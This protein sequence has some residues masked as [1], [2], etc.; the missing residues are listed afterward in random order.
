MAAAEPAHDDCVRLLLDRGANVNTQAK[1]GATAV[2]LVQAAKTTPGIPRPFVEH[3]DEIIA[4]LGNAGAAG[5]EIE[6][7]PR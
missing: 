7:R 3:L 1:D 6:I 4:I 5:A 2:S